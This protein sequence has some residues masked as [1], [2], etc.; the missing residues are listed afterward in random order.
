MKVSRWFTPV[1]LFVLIS[2]SCE[3]EIISSE[4]SLAQPEKSK[5]ISTAAEPFLTEIL[6][7][8]G[9]AKSRNGRTNGSGLEINAD[10]AFKVL[11]LDSS[12][13]SYTFRVDNKTT[14][15][16]FTNL[17]FKKVNG[18]FRAFYLVYESDHLWPFDMMNFTG[19]VTSYNLSFNEITRQYFINGKVSSQQGNGR[20]QN[21]LPAVDADKICEVNGVSTATGLDLPCFGI[22]KVLVTLD[23]TRCREISN[24]VPDYSGGGGGRVTYVWSAGD[25]ILYNGGGGGGSGGSGSG[26]GST[27]DNGDGV[28]SPTGG[29]SCSDVIGVYY[30]EPPITE[31]LE[32]GLEKDPFLLI[33]IPCD[34]LPKWQ[35]LAQNGASQNIKDKINGLQSLNTDW[36]DDWAVQTL[37]GANGTIVNMDYFAVN[38]STMPINPSTGQQFTPES[39]LDYFRRNINDF[40]EGSTFGPYCETQ[41]LCTQETALWNSNNPTGAIVYIDIPGDD[42]AVI[43]SEYTPSYWYF[44]T[45]E[46]PGAG[47]HPVSGTRQFGFEPSEGGGYNFFVRGVDRFDSNIMENAAYARFV[48]NPFQGADDLWES[49]QEGL[50]NFVNSNQ[51][52]SIIPNPTRYRPDWIKVQDVLDGRKPVSDLGCQ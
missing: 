50:S 42:G 12:S 1:V 44:M 19:K 24:D 33:D 9:F 37:S 26:G 4:T 32:F 11:Q 47:N 40:V 7:L 34:Q 3:E 27:C 49:F 41:S 46:A 45:L 43:C 10:S 8:A 14:A 13:Y 38:I 21:C 22:R 39:L 17:V 28:T 18:G 52:A 36:F 25:F 2:V 6:D 31:I 51:G 15:T 16:S 23:Y 30:P 29:N 20:T 5:F 35:T 48:G